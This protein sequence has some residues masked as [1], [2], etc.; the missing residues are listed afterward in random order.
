MGI[1]KHCFW[2]ENNKE[3]GAL[4]SIAPLGRL[5]VAEGLDRVESCGLARRKIAE[6]HAYRRREE[7]ADRHLNSLW[8]TMFDIVQTDDQ[9]TSV[10]N[11]C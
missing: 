1:V 4:E 5:F 11:P 6:D 9:R 10:G 7:E 8:K 2:I 3:K